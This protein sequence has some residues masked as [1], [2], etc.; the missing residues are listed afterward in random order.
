MQRLWRTIII[1]LLIF[2]SATRVHAGVINCT[3]D[4]SQLPAPASIAACA[5]HAQDLQ[6]QSLDLNSLYIGLRH[7]TLDT[8]IE[9]IMSRDGAGV[10]ACGKLADTSNL[11]LAAQPDTK[12]PEPNI[13]LLLVMGMISI[14]LVR[15]RVS[16]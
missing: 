10:I 16:C 7:G 3:L 9:M 5:T 15:R 8:V 2:W 12:I 4:D 13:G 11:V 14:Y 6:Y 1:G